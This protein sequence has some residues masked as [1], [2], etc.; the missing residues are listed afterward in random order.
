MKPISLF[1]SIL[2]TFFIP[3]L[4]VLI[5]LWVIIPSLLD[6]GMS[7]HLLEAPLY[8][9]YFTA[10]IG[11]SLLGLEK[12]RAPSRPG[13]ISRHGFESNPYP[14]QEAWWTLGLA[15]FS[16]VMY[17]GL[18]FTVD[19]LKGPVFTPPAWL[20]QP[21]QVLGFS[22][23]ENPWIPLLASGHC[24]TQCAGRRILVAGLPAPPS[25]THTRT[26][27]LDCTRFALDTLP[28]LLALEYPAYTSRMHGRRLREP[29]FS[30]YHSSADISFHFQRAGSCFF[31]AGSYKRRIMRTE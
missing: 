3:W 8:A 17:V 28:Q 2:S 21:D 16:V 30:K 19:L 27:C 14:G 4:I 11:A 22:I 6:Q 1:G 12:R 5:L 7:M 18:S 20:D 29:A 15:I 25:G 26:P 13:P 24:H 9:L 10:L 31:A 23:Q